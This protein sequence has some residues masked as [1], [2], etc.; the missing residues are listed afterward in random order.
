MSSGGTT[1]GVTAASAIAA[2]QEAG[3]KLSRDNNK[4]SY[5][6]FTNVILVCIEL[7][8]QFYDVPRYFRILGDNGAEE[9]VQYSNAGIVP[10]AQGTMVDGVPMEMGVEVGYRLPLFD[11]D[12]TAEKQSPYT[13]LA[14]NELALQFYQAGFFTPENADAALSCLDMMDFDRKDFVT[15]RIEQNGTLFK[16][17]QQTQQIA[18]QMAQALDMANGTQ[19]APQLMQQFAAGAQAMA[20]GGMSGEPISL[21]GL[22][23]EARESSITRNARIQAAQG[24]TP[25]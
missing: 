11:I 10:Q 12:V 24:A 13:K 4:G 8:R 18:L 6:A 1:G 16:M 5:R 23:P 2:M 25:R 21:E 22:N 19:M 20:G 14:Q 3:N 7:V 15:Q 9:F 17:L